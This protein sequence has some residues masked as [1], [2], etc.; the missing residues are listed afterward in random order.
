MVFYLLSSINMKGLKIED[1]Q[2]HRGDS[3]GTEKIFHN[4]HGHA[5]DKGVTG[6]SLHLDIFRT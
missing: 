1:Y 2:Y 5:E 3:L 6:E 4:D